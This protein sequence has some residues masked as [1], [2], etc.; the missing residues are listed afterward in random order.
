M[1]AVRF[2]GKFVA[3]L[4]TALFGVLFTLFIAVLFVRNI[5]SYEVI[6]SSVRDFDILSVTSKEVSYNGDKTIREQISEELL[7]VGVSLEVINGFF[8]SEEIYDIVTDYSYNY[9]N[10]VLFGGSKPILSESKMVSIFEKQYNLYGYDF[11][12]KRNEIVTYVSLFCDELNS[13]IPSVVDIDNMGYDVGIVRKVVDMIFSNELLISLVFTLVLF[14]IFIAVCLWSKIR[15]LKYITLPIILEGIIILVLNV[16]EVKF[17]ERFVNSQGIVDSLILNI[18]SNGVNKFLVL[19]IALIIIG[20]IL[21]IVSVILMK[22]SKK[23]SNELLDDVIRE[24]VVKSGAKYDLRAHIATSDEDI[25]KIDNTMTNLNFEEKDVKEELKVEIDNKAVN[26]VEYNEKVIVT[27]NGEV[28]KIEITSDIETSEIPVVL[29]FVIKEENKNDKEIGSNE[30]LPVVAN[31]VR[32]LEVVDKKEILPVVS[33]GLDSSMEIVEVNDEEIESSVQ[34]EVSNVT[35]EII[36]EDVSEE[37]YDSEFKKEDA[38][39]IDFVEMDEDIE[40]I[41]VNKDLEVKVP[42]SVEVEVVSPKKG[43]D[44]KVDLSTSEEPEEEEIEFL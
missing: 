25:D 34:E 12:E 35:E 39:N 17:M 23:R 41:V 15:A 30:S 9:I 14:Y 18:F 27:E 36:I 38:S 29:P 24:E 26:K 28:D 33:E 4:L 16:S 40:E 11:N 22:K 42:N 2:L 8:E 5:I 37:D 7:G 31:E 6:D 10:Y 3:F 21:L 1:R 32:E 20:L 19:G 43:N 13:L 44:I